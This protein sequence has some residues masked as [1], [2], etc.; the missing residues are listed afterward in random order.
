MGSAFTTTPVFGQLPANRPDDLDDAYLDGGPFPLWPIVQETA[1]RT[2]HLH[3]ASYGLLVGGDRLTVVGT[4]NTGVI[5]VTVS[6]IEALALLDPSPV[7]PVWRV[8]S[9]PETSLD[10]GV[11][12]LAANTHYNVFA[13]IQ[14][15]AVGYEVV[16]AAT[17]P[18]S[19]S[20]LWKLG[21]ADTHRFI[22][23]FCT[24]GA[25]VPLPMFVRKGRAHYVFSAIP[26][27]GVHRVLSVGGTSATVFTTVSCAAVVPS[28]AR[29]ARLFVIFDPDVAGD[30]VYFRTTG[31]AAFARA[32][33]GTVA[34]PIAFET[35]IELSAN[36]EFDYQVTAALDAVTAYVVGYE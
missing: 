18:V 10:L 23:T 25:G 29:V 17:A 28:H 20:G 14:G 35:D 6:M 9:V 31:T 13:R 34:G 16:S 2:D 26:N 4:A 3:R 12:V 22:G 15:G 1:N 32:F 19:A 27:N 7:P 33:P 21:A 8:Q 5:G 30:F 36:Q 11:Q 24:N